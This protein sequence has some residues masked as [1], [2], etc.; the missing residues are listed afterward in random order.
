MYVG[1]LAQSVLRVRHPTHTNIQF[2][3]AIPA[4]YT[5][6][7]EAS[8]QRLQHLLAQRLQA[9]HLLF[10]W[11][12]VDAITY[13]CGR[14]G[15]LAEAEVLGEAQVG[16]GVIYLGGGIIYHSVIHRCYKMIII[17]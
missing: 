14:A 2:G 11:L 6:H 3:R 12:I 10:R 7:A 15:K 9:L 17:R 8:A 5:Y 16:G 4:G 1:G 13:G